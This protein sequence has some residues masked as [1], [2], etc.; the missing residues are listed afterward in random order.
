MIILTLINYYYYLQ[1]IYN[2]NWLTLSFWFVLQWSVSLVY[3]YFPDKPSPNNIMY[4]HN[5]SVLYIVNWSFSLF[6]LFF[7]YTYKT[8]HI[9]QLYPILFFNTTQEYLPIFVTPGDILTIFTILQ[10]NLFLYFFVISK[11]LFHLSIK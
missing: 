6:F 11:F 8:D 7:S 1:F 3:S 5:V 4:M 9:T 2:Y 10:Y